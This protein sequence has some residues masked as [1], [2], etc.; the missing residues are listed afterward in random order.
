MRKKLL[1]VTFMFIICIAMTGTA[2]AQTLISF[3]PSPH[4]VSEPGLTFQINVTVTN[5]PAIIQWML[6]ISWNASVIEFMDI[7]EGPFLSQDGALSTTFLAKPYVPGSGNLSEVTCILM[8]AGTTSGSGTLTT[9]TFNATEVGE[10]DLTIY[11][12][13]L[14]DEGWNNQT[15]SKELGHVTVIPEF[16][17]SVILPLFLVITAVTVL[18]AKMAWSR[19]RRGYIDAP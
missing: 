18:I 15:Y 13:A 16:P 5:S 14:L 9:I 11:E 12:S 8:V 7:D 2:K 3:V 10:T 4:Q 6:K 1:L 19:R 17:A